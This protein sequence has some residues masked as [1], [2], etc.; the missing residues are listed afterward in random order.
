ME[1]IK[2]RYIWC[3]MLLVI[4]SSI[5]V[6]S[7]CDDGPVSFSIKGRVM[8]NET[9]IV[10]ATIKTDTGLEVV[11]DEMG[12]FEFLDLNNPVTLSFSAD[13]YVFETAKVVVFKE[14]KDLVI[15]AQQVYTLSGRVVSSEVGVPNAVVEVTGLVNRT[16]TTDSYGYFSV[17][18]IAGESTVKVKKD[19]FVFETKTATIDNKNLTFSGATNISVSV[20][21][22]DGFVI[23]NA[24]VKVNDNSLDFVD[25][26]YTIG[27]IA[28]GSVVVPSL[29]NYH[30]EPAQV[31]ISQENQQISFVAYPIY[32]VSGV[33]SSGNIAVSGVNVRI[34]SETVATSDANGAW[35]VDGLWGENYFSFSHSLY[36]FATKSMSAAGQINSNG[37]FTLRGTV[38]DDLENGALAYV[39]VKIGQSSTY[40]DEMGKFTLANVSLGDVVEFEKSGYF[41]TS[42]TLDSTLQLNVFATPYYSAHITV[43]DDD[44]A[45]IS[46][47][48]VRVGGVD[49]QTNTSGEI[50]LLNLVSEF[51]FEASFDGYTSVNG[52]IT[53]SDNSKTVVLN[54]YF[55]LSLSAVSGGIKLD[56]AVANINDNSYNLNTDGTFTLPTLLSSPTEITVSA[57][58]YN[59]LTLIADKNHNNLLFDLTYTVSGVVNNGELSAV[60]EIID[61]DTQEVLGK[62]NLDG[63]FEFSTTGARTI[64]A[65]ADGLNFE[66]VEVNSAALENFNASYSISGVLSAK[67][68]SVA[69]LV[70][71]LF[72]AEDEWTY[73]VDADGEYTFSDL[74]GEYTL[75]VVSSSSLYPTSYTVTKGGN[76]YDFSANGYAVSGTV[77]CGGVGLE[78]VKLSAGDYTAYTRS[79]GTFAFDFIMGE[80]TLIA[81][82][83][84]YSFNTTYQISADSSEEDYEFIATYSISGYVLSGSAPISGVIVTIGEAENESTVETDAEGYF[85]FNGLSGTLPITFS[86][87]GYTFNGL[88]SVSKPETLEILANFAVSGIVKTG[89]DVLGGIVVTNG[90]V[91]TTTDSTGAFTLNGVSE[92]DI[93]SARATG[94][95]FNTAIAEF[96]QNV[97]FT[98]TF[99]LAGVVKVSGEAKDGVTVRLLNAAGEIIAT[100]TTANGGK[101]NFAAVSGFGSLEFELAGY[102][103]A[104]VSTTGPTSNAQI[105]AVFKVNGYVRFKNSSEAIEGV[106]VKLNNKSYYTNAQGFFEI[107][108]LSTSGVL[109]FEKQGYDFDTPMVQFSGAM[110]VEV[111]ATYFVTVSVRSGS[112]TLDGVEVE[113]AD[114]TTIQTEETPNTFT[115]RGLVGM[116]TITAGAAGYNDGS[117]TVSAPLA[118]AKIVLSYN[119]TIN[120]SGASASAKLDNIK[121]EWS[122]ESETRNHT[123]TYTE[124]TST[125]VLGDVVGVGSWTLTRDGYKFIPEQGA[126]YSAKT[127][128]FNSQFDKVYS[129]KGNVSTQSGV[130][131]AGMTVTATSETTN[132]VLSTTFTDANGAYNLTNLV[133]SVI[134]NAVLSTTITGGSDLSY[135]GVTNTQAANS[136]TNTLNITISNQDYAYWLVQSGYQEIRDAPSYLN[137]SSGNVKSSA[138]IVG[139]IAQ[140]VTSYRQ[141]DATG[142]FV[143]NNKN[144]GTKVQDTCVGLLGYRDTALSATD[145]QYKKLNGSKNAN[146]SNSVVTINYGA[147][148]WSNTTVSG[149][150]SSFGSQP[151]DLFI[152]NL[153]KNYFSSSVVSGTAGGTLTV[154]FSASGDDKT[155]LGNYYTQMC[156]LSGTTNI[157]YKSVNATYTFEYKTKVEGGITKG[158][159]QLKTFTTT[160]KYAVVAYGVTADTTAS[161]T[162]KYNIGGANDYLIDKSAFDGWA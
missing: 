8:Y 62:T 120:I 67:N 48:T 1:I 31:T 63:E 96:N 137:S 94:Y 118:N 10:G 58:G 110:T 117:V 25:D 150:K 139:E 158:Y 93:I 124:V 6:L 123:Y 53:R 36:K 83:D 154:S 26:A 91:E 55:N 138:P 77:Y 103:F 56:S 130:G 2:Q 4:L 115:I 113:C 127:N 30:F 135:T 60:A 41:L 84:G 106:T 73:T 71:S 152:Y 35:R 15:R 105:S 57:T 92:G 32:S 90:I 116:H 114:A 37:T 9:S 64:T 89:D 22:V 126:F 148:G 131:V 142:K 34:N 101:Y 39:S 75:A 143:S 18:N 162:E 95:T 86:K 140:T 122:D 46:G 7:G 156:A 51:D 81:S 54:E 42:K 82:K 13:G 80:Q 74:S 16:A 87:D 157:T 72:K 28:L 49:Y 111:A 33:T 141:K 61:I 100:M 19:G 52:K 65:L 29:E 97:V 129:L 128:T 69:G 68:E 45:P 14:T 20:V 98:G 79:D 146:N 102:E 107:T 50:D 149:Y 3:A 38:K 99:T 17:E 104:P 12:A 24:S 85:E 161:L 147:T 145:M 43:L 132:K 155:L 70:V 160:E 108:G 151:E 27:D 153:S 76:N 47:A 134:I 11:T 144:Y 40:T 21:D 125:V 109:L 5:F 44:N 121:V 66:S 159:Y 136:S 78:G 88:S 133:G 112:I 59:S 119:V 23:D